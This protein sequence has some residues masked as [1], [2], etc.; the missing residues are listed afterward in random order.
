MNKKIALIFG[1]T[2]Q[3]GYYL[4]KFLLNKNYEVHGVKRKSSTVYSYR[5]DEL[6][7]KYFLK[8]RPSFFLHY[9]DVSDSMSILNLIKKV[10]PVEI[11]NLAAQSHVKVSFEIP[12]YSSNVDALGPLRILEVIKNLNKSIKY[13]QA[14]SSEMFGNAKAP[15]NEKSL[16][17]PN[18]PYS[19]SKLYAYWITRA[20]RDAY[21]IFATNGIL[22]NHESPLRGETF[23]TKKITQFVANEKLNKNMNQVLK[24]GNLD[25]KRDW[26]HAEDYVKAMWKMMQHSKPDDYVIAT[27]RSTSVRK[28]V[29]MS[30]KFIGIDIKWVGKKLNEKGINRSTGKV[31]VK[32]DERLF[33]PN[34]VNHLRGDSKKAK[35]I[36]NWKHTIKL[37]KLIE[38]MIEFD[39]IKNK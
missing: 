15:Q 35:K 22:F 21:K 34:E 19:I 18:S 1:V 6:Y 33:R 27:G 26:G 2:G 38:E 31:L 4:S 24:L 8:K 11:Y 37:E 17:L 16:F 9:G 30:F 36:L 28:F 20:Y 5:T 39:L 7:E 12:D 23:V 13:Y 25:A 14:S 3:D 29:E 32:I 10:K